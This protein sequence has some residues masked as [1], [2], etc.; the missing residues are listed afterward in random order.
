MALKKL[1]HLDD[2][3]V[4][5]RKEDVRG[6]VLYERDGGRI[7]KIDDML[8]DTDAKLVRTVIL[9]NGERFS[10]DDIDITSDGVYLHKGT[11]TQGH[12]QTHTEPRV[13]IYRGSESSS[14]R[15]RA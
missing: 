5:D 2:W 14:T 12:T 9:D 10:V 13:K 15:P 7:G 8:V 6:K 11:H 4:S 3:H 1:S